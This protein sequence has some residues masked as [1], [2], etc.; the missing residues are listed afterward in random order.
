MR[1]WALAG[2]LAAATALTSTACSAQSYPD[3]PV[4]MII[5]FDA[6]G[7]TDLMARA[8]QEEM[9]R[10]LGQPLV[11][12]NKPGAAATLGTGELARAKPDGVTI[13]MVPIGPIAIQPN[14][15]KLPYGPESFDYICQT[16]DVPIFLMVPK[17][18]PYKTAADVIAFAK[19]NPNAFLYG[20]SGPGTMP[21]IATAAFLNAAGA[22]GTHIP[23]RGSGEMAQALLAGTVMAFSDA[24]SIAA[25]NDLR[26]L[27]VYSAEREK[28]HPDVPTMK[29]LGYDFTGSIWGG[30]IAP[31]GLPQPVA[32]KLEQACE[33]AATSEGYKQTAAKLNSPALY[34]NARDF[35]AFVEAQSKTMG[36]VV[37]AVG[38]EAK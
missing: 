4:Q 18:S 21:H 27:A 25:A 29:E 13:G 8:L 35:K 30:I 15:R 33:A 17:T 12:I 19:A 6:G 14:I 7:N 37:R 28:T 36:A 23:F 3:K 32:A 5:P 9:S 2:L 20:S 31:K 24:P 38:L 16:Y 11:P 22:T 1:Q 26:V 10:A 34:K